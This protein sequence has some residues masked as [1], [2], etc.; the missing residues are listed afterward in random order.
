MSRI[1]EIPLTTIKQYISNANESCRGP[2]LY[3]GPDMMA[4]MTPTPSSLLPFFVVSKA[5][6]ASSNLKLRRFQY[7]VQCNLTID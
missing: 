4:L 5:S 2:A 1:T 3:S 7:A 6:F